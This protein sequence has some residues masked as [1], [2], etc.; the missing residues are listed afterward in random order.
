[1]FHG[2]VDDTTM[3]K[4]TG[5]ACA[6]N[7]NSL[8]IVVD[9]VVVVV[10]KFPNNIIPLALVGYEKIVANSALRASLALYHLKSNRYSWNN[11]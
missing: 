8:P 6:V 10:R 11:C 7:C 1:M 3:T 5:R 4:F 9:K 2:V